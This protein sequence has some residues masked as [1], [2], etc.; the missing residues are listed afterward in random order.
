VTVVG[1]LRNV[2]SRTPIQ[3]AVSFKEP[4]IGRYEDRLELV[5]E[6]TQLKKQFVIARSL[7]VIV[8]NKA[9]HE[10]LQPKTA[11][12]P[13]T[14]STRKIIPEQDIVEGVKP[15]ALNAIRYVVSLPKA[16][17]PTHLHNIL[18]SSETMAKVVSTVRKV[19]MPQDFN[20]DTYG[21]HFKQLLWVEEFKS[22]YVFRTMDVVIQC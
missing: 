16:T 2:T 8:G 14:R 1:N 17:I 15:P 12:V 21:R 13:R 5:F 9:E 4:F 18:A 20:S 22:E 19:F 7:K 11:Y 10:A 6:D 3:L